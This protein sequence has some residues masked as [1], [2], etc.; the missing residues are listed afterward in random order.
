MEATKIQ[1]NASLRF[2]PAGELIGRDLLI[3]FREQ[4][5]ADCVKLLGDFNR[6]FNLNLGLPEQIAQTE[7]QTEVQVLPADTPTNC[8]RCHAPLIRRKVT[9]QD[10]KSYGKE[11]LGCV[12]YYKK[13]CL[14][15]HWL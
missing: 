14:F 13:G 4:S 12:N 3:N 9:K 11:F 6:Q 7:P 5:V 1:S 10:S 15:T 8:P 2:N